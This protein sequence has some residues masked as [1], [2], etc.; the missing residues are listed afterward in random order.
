MSSTRPQPR[1]VRLT[2]TADA[3]PLLIAESVAETLRLGHTIELEATGPP[4]SVRAI[5][6]LAHAQYRLTGDG[7]E[8]R[9]TVRL[10][11]QAIPDNDETTVCF[12]V[13]AHPA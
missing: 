13:T 1:T 3:Q 11:N 10:L 4:A 6:V 2:V 7:L 8:L 12:M 5:E 9:F